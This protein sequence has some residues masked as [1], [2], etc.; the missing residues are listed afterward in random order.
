MTINDSIET[1]VWL[2][3]D[4]MRVS[5]VALGISLFTLGIIIYHI[6]IMERFI[7]TIRQHFTSGNEYEK[8]KTEDPYGSLENAKGVRIHKKTTTGEEN[9]ESDPCRKG[10]IAG[11]KRRKT[12]EGNG[13]FLFDSKT[14]TEVNGT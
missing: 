10:K 4:P 13:A 3:E 7:S 5:Y 2:L 11:V 14:S 6:R 8:V 1:I 12:S 9:V